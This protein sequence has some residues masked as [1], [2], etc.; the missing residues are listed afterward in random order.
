VKRQPNGFSSGGVVVVISSVLLNVAI[1]R[2][3][4]RGRNRLLGAEVR[5]AVSRVQPLPVGAGDNSRD[6]AVGVLAQLLKHGVGA[7]GL[8]ERARV[9]SGSMIRRSAAAGG[10]SRGRERPTGGGCCS[11]RRLKGSPRRRPPAPRPCLPNYA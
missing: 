11:P 10:Y 1:L 5:S 4:G 2:S 6:A 9:T 8:S 7:V 3:C